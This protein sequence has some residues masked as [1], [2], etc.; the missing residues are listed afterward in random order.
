MAGEKFAETLEHVQH[1]TPPSGERRT[2]TLINA[3]ENPRTTMTF[4]YLWLLS[5]AV[6]SCNEDKSC[7]IQ[8]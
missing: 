1:S 5:G 7:Y 2:H 3:R 4:M 6:S 8:Y